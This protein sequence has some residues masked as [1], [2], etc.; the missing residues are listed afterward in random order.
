M[1]ASIMIS[2]IAP[3]IFIIA[4]GYCAGR[5]KDFDAHQTKGFSRLALRYALP[6]ALF[7]GMAQFN[8][9]LLLQQGPV[10]VIMVLGYSLFFLASYLILRMK[11]F[12]KTEA[13]LLGYTVSSTAAPIYGLTV[14]VPI[15]GLQTGSGVVGLAAL[16]TNLV[17]VSVAV[18]M[19]QS[20]SMA[21]GQAASISTILKDTLKNPLVWAPV[22]GAVIS[23]SG[24]TLPDI[25]IST[26]KP[27]AVCVAAVAIFAC[28]LIL[29][30]FPVNLTSIIV[31]FGSATCIIF[32][33]LLFFVFIKAWGLKSTMAKATFVASAMPTSTPSVLF[34]QQYGKCQ[35]E[36]S[37]IMLVTT[38]GMIVAIPAAVLLSAWL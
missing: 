34:A 17:Q 10:I 22:L 5:N 35:A 21:E 33:P 7:L 36:T 2:A 1:N 23:V 9:S 14:L 37:S 26:L 13:I 4:L 31:I 18:F 19:L 29:S 27:L 25:T 6:V 32:Q 15:Y 8:K 20:A 16:V 11:K 30:S 24:I 12:G 3:V 28:G 38:V